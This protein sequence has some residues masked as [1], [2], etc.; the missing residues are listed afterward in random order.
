MPNV[1][2]FPYYKHSTCFSACAVS[3]YH[4]LSSET[5]VWNILGTVKCTASKLIF[6]KNSP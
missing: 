3:L 2:S 6:L 5:M 1:F 4:K